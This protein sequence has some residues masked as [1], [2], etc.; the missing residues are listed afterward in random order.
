MQKKKKGNNIIYNKVCLVINMLAITGQDKISIITKLELFKL[1]DV[2]VIRYNNADT[3]AQYQTKEEAQKDFIKLSN[4][5]K[6]KDLKIVAD[7]LE[8]TRDIDG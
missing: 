6:T 4:E 5:L 2:Y 7:R 3:Y 8:E 1:R